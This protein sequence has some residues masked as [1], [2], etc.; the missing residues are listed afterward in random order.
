MLAHR[1][2]STIRHA[3]RATSVA[4][5]DFC[6]RPGKLVFCEMEHVSAWLHFNT[7]QSE[8]TY[9]RMVLSQSTEPVC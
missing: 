7:L 5:V 6:H 3:G 9:H 1:L 2:I 4:F 8:S